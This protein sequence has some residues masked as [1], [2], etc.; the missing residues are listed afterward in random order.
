M[1]V[2]AGTQDPEGRCPGE[3]NVHC[4]DGSPMMSADTMVADTVVV[5]ADDFDR[6]LYPQLLGISVI[7]KGPKRIQYC[8]KVLF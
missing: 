3:L 1:R 5:V 6:T 4:L 8:S 2:P 7:K